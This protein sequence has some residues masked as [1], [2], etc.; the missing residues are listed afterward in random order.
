LLHDVTARLEVSSQLRYNHDEQLVGSSMAT[1]WIIS[2]AGHS[3]GPFS[4][5]QMQALVGDGRLASNSL[6]AHDGSTD[7]RSAG[8]EP[9][10]AWLFRPSIPAIPSEQTSPLGKTVATNTFG[11][12][13]ENLQK[14]DRIHYMIAADMKAGSIAKLEQEIFTLGTAFALFSQVWLLSS[15]Q[16]LS[17]IRNRLIQ[18]LGKHDLLFVADATNDKTAWFNFGPQADAHIRKIWTKQQAP[19]LNVLG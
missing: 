7:F 16:S 8:A 19:A 11:R 3:Y 2:V 12:H 15:D 10:L 5:L 14:N 17:A 4:G 6:V 18:Q 1:S 13:S 9:E